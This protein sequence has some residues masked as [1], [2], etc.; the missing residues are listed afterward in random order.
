MFNS[1]KKHII[2]QPDDLIIYPGHGAGSSCGKSISSGHFCT[3]G[4]QKVKNYALRPMPKHEFVAA[5][6]KELPKPP[7]Y[8]FYNAT[9]NKTLSTLEFP[10]KT[11]LSA[12]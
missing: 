7:G 12:A 9:S 3:V 6:T 1:I 8:F 11:E 5:V 2:S 10:K 4:N